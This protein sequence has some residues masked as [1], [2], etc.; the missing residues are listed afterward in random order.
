MQK[1]DEKVTFIGTVIHPEDTKIPCPRLYF[2]VGRQINQSEHDDLDALLPAVCKH[3]SGVFACL[4]T[5]AMVPAHLYVTLGGLDPNAA[6]TKGRIDKHKDDII[7]A[8]KE[9]FADRR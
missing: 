6:S 1:V 4:R 2:N 3:I 8:I 7:R 5:P 9:Y